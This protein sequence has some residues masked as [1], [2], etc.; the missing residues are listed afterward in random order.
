MYMYIHLH[1]YTHVIYIYTYIIYTHG[2]CIYMYII[3]ACII[4]T[5]PYI[6]YHIIYM[7]S[8]FVKK[9][10]GEGEVFSINGLSQL[11]IYLQEWLNMIPLLLYT[12]FNFSRCNTRDKEKTKSIIQGNSHEKLCFENRILKK[13]CYKEKYW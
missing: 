2:I 5:C 11:A 7:D 1:I 6:I 12:K 13:H 8:G 4:Y 3:Y 10:S 9:I